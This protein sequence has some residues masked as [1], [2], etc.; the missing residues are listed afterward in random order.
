MKVLK[1]GGTSVG[2]PERMHHV[3]KLIQR[4]EDS[5]IVVLSAVSGTTN[6]LVQI[7]EQLRAGK[8]EHASQII[9]DLYSKYQDFI[10]KLVYTDEARDKAQ[11]VLDE[12]FGFL[13]TLSAAGFTAALEREVLAQGELLS[14]KLFYAYLQEQQINAALLP[15]LEFMVIDDHKE[16][17]LDNIRENIQEQLARHEGTQLFITQG[18][19]CRN[20]KGEI[21]NLKRGGSDY[22]ASIIGGVLHAEEVQIWTDISG[23]HNNDPRIVKNT[24]PIARL[25]FDEAAELA[26]FGAKI[27]HPA[28]ILP[29]QKFNV[30]VRL[31]N[32]M[33]PEAEGTLIGQ[34]T[35]SS[36][37]RAV[38]A[39]DGITAIKIKSGRML[40]AYGFLK[41]VFEIFE[42]YR[43][44]ID[45]ITTSEVAVSLTID[46][47][48]YLG[49]IIAELS[50]FGQVEVDKNQAIICLVGYQL[51]EQRG[52]VTKALEALHH[53][54]LRMISYGGSKHNVSILID[55][56]F[57][58]E[59]LTSLN[60]NL[61]GGR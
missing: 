52:I 14:T 21:D 50:E 39:K 41:N 2:A 54:P 56:Q 43:T 25:S 35:E 46:D 23:M 31:L 28:S 59:A 5:K 7:G 34:E 4:E 47:N 38:A 24:Y 61:F 45:M 27:L 15:A 57:K 26:Y 33:E 36:G 60:E 44:P 53:I 1:F 10:L 55:A 58:K 3:A 16:P 40:M 9:E 42:R 11:E 51:S 17:E 12:H 19:I 20:H 37:V 22:S 32:T 6:T 13:R 49:Q 30:P 18:F 48:T 8:E 29:T